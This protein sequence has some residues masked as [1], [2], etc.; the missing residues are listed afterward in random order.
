MINDA[1]LAYA[2]VRLSLAYASVRFL[3]KRLSPRKPVHCVQQ[4]TGCC[5]Y[6]NV[7]HFRPSAVG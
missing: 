3:M 4:H 5:G 2:L 1:L 7:A 6:D